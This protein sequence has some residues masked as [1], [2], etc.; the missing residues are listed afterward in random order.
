VNCVQEKGNLMHRRQFLQLAVLALGVNRCGVLFAQQADECA[1]QLGSTGQWG[2]LAEL[3]SFYAFE[4]R[5]YCEKPI[6]NQG[7]KLNFPKFAVVKEQLAK[8]AAESKAATSVKYIAHDDAGQLILTTELNDAAKWV[9]TFDSDLARKMK[10]NHS[11]DRDDSIR[12]YRIHH[13]VGLKE[14]KYL[15]VAEKEEKITDA[16][17]TRVVHRLLLGPKADH[18]FVWNNDFSGK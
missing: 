6:N 2:F 3:G 16:G 5:I 7:R 9:I 10:A 11:T 13:A 18:S 1:F 12:A 17:R 4:D 8:P 14:N 15:T